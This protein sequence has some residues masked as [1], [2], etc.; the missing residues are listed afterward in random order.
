LITSHRLI[1]AF[2]VKVIK[3]MPLWKIAGNCLWRN[4][5]LY[6]LIQSWMLLT[7]PGFAEAPIFKMKFWL[8]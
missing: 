6:G 4:S 7:I 8:G 1:Y 3:P 5:W 2:D